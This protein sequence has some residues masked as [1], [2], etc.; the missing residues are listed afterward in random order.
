MIPLLI[1]RPEPGASVTAERARA[2]GL[3][4]LVR[5][6][7][8]V[9]P[10][11]WESPD[12]ALFDALLLTSANALRHGGEAIIRYRH[13]PVF[14]VGSATTAAARDAGFADLTEGSGNAADALQAMAA[15]GYS[16]PL[17]ISGEHRT[18]YPHL[19]FTVTSRTVYSARPVDVAI[20]QGRCVAL[21]HS[22]RAA[23]LF[24]QLCSLP[25][26][27]DVVSISPAVT[28]AAGE[29]WRSVATASTPDDNAMLALAA[30]LCDGAS[31][32]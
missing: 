21:I 3:S 7:F 11:K 14:A 31:H 12:P 32:A 19:P 20:P 22:A 17:H 29:R 24:T 10:V 30:M 28:L 2:L 1:L 23:E 5:P 16:R 8:A 9:E 4:P 27:V 6:L 25:A 13:L 15:A 18:P 26:K